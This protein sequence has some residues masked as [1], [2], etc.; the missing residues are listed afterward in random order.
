VSPKAIPTPTHKA[1][2]RV[3]VYPVDLGRETLVSGLILL[4]RSRGL[5]V[6]AV[7][8]WEDHDA[9]IAASPFLWG[10]MLATDHPAGCI[11]VRVRRRVRWQGVTVAV[12]AAILALSASRAVFAVVFALVVF[13]ALWGIWRTGPFLTRLLM[14]G[15]A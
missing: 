12:I 3:L 5:R 14:R 15:P 2:G 6:L 1:K 4:L 13:T 10:E 7:T 9:R 11:Q 8:G